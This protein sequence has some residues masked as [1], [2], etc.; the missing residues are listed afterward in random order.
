MA[1]EKTVMAAASHMPKTMWSH[2]VLDALDK[3]NYLATT[4]KGK[5]QESPNTN[6]AQ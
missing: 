4:K 1:E 2:A 6:T 5:I 3:G